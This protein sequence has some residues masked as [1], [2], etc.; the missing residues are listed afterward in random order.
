VTTKISSEPCKA[1][2]AKDAVIKF[3]KSELDR[4]ADELHD[5]D[6]TINNM[7]NEVSDLECELEESERQLALLR[8]G[9]G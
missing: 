5:A 4:Y 8:A 6:E 3:L 9:M 7:C 2:A 1:C